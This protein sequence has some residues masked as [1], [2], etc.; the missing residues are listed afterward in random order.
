MKLKRTIYIFFFLFVFPILTDGEKTCDFKAKEECNE[1]ITLE[2]SGKE[3][4]FNPGDFICSK[5]KTY[6][7]G[8]TIDGVLAICD[9]DIKLWSV[10]F[11]NPS[12][13]AKFQNSGK[14]VLYDS[15]LSPVWEI[16]TKTTQKAT[17]LS[18]SNNG[19]L[20][21]SDKSDNIL[22]SLSPE[23]EATTNS[24][25]STSS[26]GTIAPSDS[27]QPMS[28]IVPTLSK[29]ENSCNFEGESNATECTEGIYSWYS[30]RE[31]RIDRGEFICNSNFLFG[32][33][34]D[35]VLSIC[36]RNTGVVWSVSIPDDKEPE[37][38]HYQ[39]QVC[40]K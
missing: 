40:V 14:F 37:F 20:E 34:L 8:L 39:R 32:L 16:K 26:Q 24:P 10:G 19:T 3:R 18:L 25:S 17:K 28:T 36:S 35:G 2:M 27:L 5:N 21:V 23:V 33:N 4:Q 11:P 9:R 29:K 12:L 1:M 6:R 7:F 15:T 22:W 38:A 31:R 13:F 30:T